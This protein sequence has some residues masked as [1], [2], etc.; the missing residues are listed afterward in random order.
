MNIYLRKLESVFY[1][2][3]YHCC[4]SEADADRERRKSVYESLVL[5]QASSCV[6]ELSA[7]NAGMISLVVSLVVTPLHC[8]DLL[9]GD[10]GFTKADSTPPPS[11]VLCDVFPIFDADICGLEMSFNDIFVT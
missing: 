2:A 9:I 6:K 8:C 3:M 1:S 10:V 5:L 7:V 4:P 11:S